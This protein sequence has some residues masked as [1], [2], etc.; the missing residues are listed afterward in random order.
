MNEKSETLHET[1]RKFAHKCSEL[2]GFPWTFII[3]VA[4]IIVWGAT[5]PFFGF[6]DTWQLIINTSTTIITFLMVFLIQNTQ[7]RESKSLQLKLDELINSIKEARN[8]FI[9]LENLSDEELE[10]LQ[11]QFRQLQQRQNKTDSPED[12]AQQHQQ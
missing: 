8:K 12:K 6:S 10:T 5:G 9:D 2:A 7:N 4:I 1:F 3:A 11:D